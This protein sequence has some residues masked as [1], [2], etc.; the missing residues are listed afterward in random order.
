VKLH[1]V[2]STQAVRNGRHNPHIAAGD[3]NEGILHFFD[4]IAVT[5]PD[6]KSLSKSFPELSIRSKRNRCASEFTLIPWYN[7]GP[8]ILAD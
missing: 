5:H 3:L 6:V 4:V 7:R 2:D 1:S 8:E